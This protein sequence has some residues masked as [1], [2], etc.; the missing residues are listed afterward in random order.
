MMSSVLTLPQTEKASLSVRAKALVFEDPKSRALL[1]RIRQVAPSNATVLVV[2]E[3][4]TGKEI[5][6]RHIH[7]LSYRAGRPFVAVNCGAFSEHL[8][9]SDLFG[10]EKGAFTGALGAKAGWFEAAA[11]GT[12]FL[13]EIGDLPFGA[14]VKLLRVLQEQEV[15]RLGS[16]QP[17]SV[18]VRLVAATNV[19]LEEAVAAGSFREDLY[20][21]LAVMKVTV[22]ALRDRPGD[23]LPL[24]R[25]FLEVYAS[26]LRTGAGWS[27]PVLTPDAEQALLAHPW[28]GNIRELEN[29]IHHASLVCRDGL[30]T[31]ADL[32]LVTMPPRRSAV[33]VSFETPAPVVA[34]AP[35]PAPSEDPHQLLR[36]ALAALYRQ[37]APHLWDD[38]EE[39][40]M[41]SAYE[42]ARHNQLGTARLLGISRNV[43]RARLLQFGVLHSREGDH[44]QPTPTPATKTVRIGCLRFG[45]LVALRLT[46]ALER[47]WAE[48]G[49]A[50]QWTTFP[51]GP[52]LIEAMRAGRLDLGM[53][54]ET[55]SVFG[56]A[57]NVPL[58][59]LAAEP[60]APGDAAILVH[61]D[62]PIRRV[63]D[64]KGKTIA[65]N[66]N[67]NSDYLVL[68]AIEEVHLDYD[69]VT[70]TSTSAGSARAA[71]ERRQVDAWATWNLLTAPVAAAHG[72]R[73]LRDAT[74]LAGNVICYVG[75]RTFSNENP[76]LVTELVEELAQAGVWMNENHEAAGELMAPHLG[77]T[78]ATVVAALT[79]RRFGARPIDAAV[80]A[81]QQI[82][83]DTLLRARRIP[84]PV[85]VADARWV[86]PPAT[87]LGAK[88]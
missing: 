47:R 8:I 39:T 86:P 26:R 32:P 49:I 15:V 64:L 27:L 61:S 36:A 3:T 53:V 73:V 78:P 1:T 67:T 28:M 76:D 16:R 66:R 46:G 31:P 60:P 18:D 44:D 55:A 62:S 51:H 25:Y 5:V 87:A 9:E 34:P 38:I 80:L 19:K 43:V 12:L 88:G 29:A 71:F 48:K 77:V 2:G 23:V 56:Q 10:H 17:I 7:E 81:G 50:L 41:R 70:L 6:A 42:H 68:K 11:G 75:T 14:Q 40:I 45:P 83:A 54:S 21:R 58:V 59:Y 57:A 22:E 33:P 24:A 82:V 37:G 84:R 63:E 30:I 85:A 4:G 65:A 69:D 52:S 35:R 20:Y 13:D 79:R 72:T 74:G